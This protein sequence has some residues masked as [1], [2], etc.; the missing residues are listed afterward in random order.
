MTRKNTMSIRSS[1]TKLVVVGY[2]FEIGN[3]VGET[4][5]LCR[6]NVM[7]AGHR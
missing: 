7:D 3:D 2:L 1:C 5:F 4:L 6:K